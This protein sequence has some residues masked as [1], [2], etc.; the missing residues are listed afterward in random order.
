MT[1]IF[2]Y[3][4]QCTG[5]IYIYLEIGSVKKPQL[6]DGQGHASH[7]QWDAIR[8]KQVD[9]HGGTPGAIYKALNEIYG[10]LKFLI[11]AITERAIVGLLLV[12]F[13]YSKFI[14]VFCS[15]FLQT[16]LLSF[17]RATNQ[18]IYIL[19]TIHSYAK[20]SLGRFDFS[21]DFRSA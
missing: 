10:V 14:Y 16:E 8:E 3:K 5:E 20:F 13:I 6:T 1:G 17:I 7:A 12:F 15:R 4:F 18:L 19:G 21:S 2:Y 11:A 9:Y